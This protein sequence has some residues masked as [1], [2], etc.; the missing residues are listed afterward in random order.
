M[1]SY[2]L[3]IFDWD[4]TLYDSIGH[5][6]RCTQQTAEQLNLPKPE[7]RL[8]RQGIG[9][10]F[11]ESAR[12]VFG[13]VDSD[14][15]EQVRTHFYQNWDKHGQTPALF[16]G[17]ETVLTGLKNQGY[18]LAVATGKGRKNFDQDLDDFAMQ[19]FF[20]ATRCGD[21]VFSKPH[22]QM[23]EQLIEEFAVDAGSTLMI[24]D[25]RHDMQLAANAG[26]D[27]LGVTYG[28]DD[29]ETLALHGCKR[30]VDNIAGVLNFLNKL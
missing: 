5:I 21:E 25:S 4:G 9:L 3:I 1:K 10:S 15:I 29:K 18:L 28:V 14:K 11:E 19:S 22:P 12:K 6:E 24:G 23:L 17:S 16:A 20:D 13:L 27:I 26:V 8:I 2:Q 7:G 30:F